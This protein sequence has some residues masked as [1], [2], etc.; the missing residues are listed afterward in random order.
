MKAFF[1]RLEENEIYRTLLRSPYTYITGAVLLSVLQVAQLASLK[2]IWGVTGPF[3]NWGA[4]VYEAF[5]GDVRSW[6]Y[7]SGKASQTVLNNGFLRDG[8]S[9]R[10][11]GII[12]GALMSTFL[13]SEFKIKKIK[14]K[15]Q[16]IAAILG[17]LLMGYGA[18]LASG[19]N[20]GALYSGIASFS[21]S[22]WVFALF[23]FLGAYMGSKLLYK[24]FM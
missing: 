2:A 17:G 19:C 7:F 13:A 1:L 10:D 6:Y 9:L 3:V 12:A 24:Y 16:V 22:G 21:F 11:V 5:G 23:L 4:W 14:S 15:K 20:I 18:R 8:A